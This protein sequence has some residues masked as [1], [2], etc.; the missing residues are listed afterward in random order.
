MYSTCIFCHSPLG[1]NEAIEF[2]PVG[3]RL[4]FDAAKGRL[5]AVCRKCERWNLT[6]IEERWEAIEQ[7]ER[8]FR[9]T[10][11]RVSTDQIGLGRLREG[12]EL[13]RIGKPL[14][15]EFAAWRY[16]D[17]FGRRRRKNFLIAGATVAAVGI[18]PF[19]GVTMGVSFGLAAQ[20]PR[21][22]LWGAMFYNR[23][24]ALALL[25]D[26]KGRPLPVSIDDADHT[27]LLPPTASEPWGLRVAHRPHPG[28]GVMWWAPSKDRA[29]TDLRGNNAMHAAAQILPR[30]NRAGATRSQLEEAVK[31][32][33][34]NED[35]NTPFDRA[36]RSPHAA[37][38]TYGVGTVL[39]L[40]P[41]EMRLAFEMA[42]HEEA[43]RQAFEGELKQLEDAWR[44]AEEIASISDD[45]FLPEEVI[46]KLAQLKNSAGQR[47]L[48]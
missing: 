39:T 9:E 13:V 7:C 43:E 27:V 10:K 36:A 40:I 19:V 6:P 38:R 25:R 4:A 11:L 34:T 41:H 42:S 45:M 31:L 15:P 12:L 32:A 44:E 8:S 37:W 48:L 35:P 16:G 23:M 24:R 47:T 1:A 5:W 3:R 28:E 46:R 18:I 29:Y 20:I 26:D 30:L 17:Q 21:L 22:G 14:R 2:F 33:T